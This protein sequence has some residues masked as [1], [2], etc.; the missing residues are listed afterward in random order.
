MAC[1]FKWST[2]FKQTIVSVF[3]VF[4]SYCRPINP[5]LNKVTIVAHL[6][7]I[8]IF[9]LPEFSKVGTVIIEPE[10]EVVWGSV[11]LRMKGGSDVCRRARSPCE[12]DAESLNYEPALKEEDEQGETP[13]TSK[14][15][16]IILKRGHGSSNS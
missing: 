13:T 8:G 10:V 16:R 11:S 2:V 14:R 1:A 5:A 12:E 7:A 3:D 6:T 4:F 15:V 9:I